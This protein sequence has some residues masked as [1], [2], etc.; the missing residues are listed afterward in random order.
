MSPSIPKEALPLLAMYVE[1]HH[2]LYMNLTGKPL[3][4]KHH[5]LIH[6]PRL[7]AE[8]G[9]LVHIWTMRW[10]G[11]H[12]TL[13][14]I[15]NSV[16]TR[17]KICLTAG[18]KCQLQLSHSFYSGSFS[19]SAPVVGPLDSNT[20]PELFRRKFVRQVFTTSLPDMSTLTNEGKLVRW[21]ELNGTKYSRG[22]TLYQDIDEETSF[23]IFGCAEDI[24]VTKIQ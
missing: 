22:V 3:S 9:P 19:K 1:D 10:E 5:N 15:T 6:Y 18:K 7:I 13:K 24:L 8:L 11:K 21:V 23:P 20:S 14:K 2:S 17:K 4:F 16:A 12:R